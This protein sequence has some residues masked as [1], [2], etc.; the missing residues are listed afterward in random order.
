MLQSINFFLNTT[1]YL[2]ND[3]TRL[4]EH[5]F[6]SGVNKRATDISVSVPD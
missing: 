1:L 4:F 3:N 5:Y 6:S 2:R